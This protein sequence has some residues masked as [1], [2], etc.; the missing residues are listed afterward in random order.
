MIKWSHKIFTEDMVKDFIDAYM[1]VHSTKNKLKY[2]GTTANK[3]EFKEIFLQDDIDQFLR[4]ALIID[5]KTIWVEE[6]HLEK[7]PT[8]SAEERKLLI[9]TAQT[10][11][12]KSIF[13]LGLNA[14]CEN[15]ILNTDSPPQYQ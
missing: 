5:K 12:I 2:G 13:I 7:S 4:V 15:K 8:L 10:K 9:L 1:D 11:I 3:V 14:E 6:I